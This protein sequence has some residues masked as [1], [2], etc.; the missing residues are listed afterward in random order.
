MVIWS[1]AIPVVSRFGMTDPE[2]LGQAEMRLRKWKC[3]RN[4]LA[5]AFPDYV[6]AH[7]VVHTYLNLKG[8][9]ATFY[10]A[11]LAFTREI[12]ATM[13]LFYKLETRKQCISEIV[14]KWGK[15]GCN[16]SILESITDMTWQLRALDKPALDYG[17]VDPDRPA[18]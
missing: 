11:Y 5:D 17:A 2:W 6:V 9:G 7:A 10:T 18:I 14:E 8:V 16:V 15:A 12:L 13:R 4:P 1:E 3:K